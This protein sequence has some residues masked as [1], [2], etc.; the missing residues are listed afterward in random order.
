MS[1]N[2]PFLILV[3]DDN[4]QNIQLLASIMEECGYEYVIAMNGHEAL[5][6][7]KVDVPDL[8]LL[9]VMMPDMDGYEVCKNIKSDGRFQDIPV[10][11]LTSK[12]DKEDIVKGFNMGGVDYVTKPFNEVELKMRIKTHCELKRIKDEQQKAFEELKNKNILLEEALIQLEIVSITDPLTTIYNRR[13]MMARIEEEIARCD[14]TGSEFSIILCD[15]DNFKIVNDRYGH[16]CGDVVL[17]ETANLMKSISRELD[18]IARWGGEE[19]LCLL[20]DTDRQGALQL[21]ERMRKSLE[22]SEFAFYGE[23]LQVTMTCG[24]AQYIKGDGIDS[25]IK[26]ADKALYAGKDGGRNCV[27]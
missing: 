26:R 15:I 16:D 7:I 14:R 6:S 22:E 17:V 23:D 19:F 25:V 12:Q 13:F 27:I 11:F 8:I 24:V 9:D 21:A 5:E 1:G 20:P 10:I 4:L 18:T 3:V 2:P